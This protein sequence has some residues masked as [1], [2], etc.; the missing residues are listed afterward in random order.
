MA[1]CKSATTFPCPVERLWHTVTDLEHTAW[2]SDLS[3]VEVPEKGRFV[4]YGRGGCPTFFVVTSC[5]P[6]RL[7]AFVME[8]GNMS[9]SWEGRFEATE[10]GCRL[11]CAERVQ[12]RRWWMR[13]LVPLYLRRQHRRYL[14][15]LARV[16]R[17]RP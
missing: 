15:D 11:I 10:Q 5:R 3:R 16:L 12:A 1:F 17:G 2:R 9:G 6:L 8:N 7:W 14:R 4:E 13:P